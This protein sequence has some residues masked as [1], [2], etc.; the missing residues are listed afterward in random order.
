MIS[1]GDALNEH[2]HIQRNVATDIAVRKQVLPARIGY[3]FG[4]QTLPLLGQTTAAILAS[5]ENHRGF[6]RFDTAVG[7][8]FIGRSNDGKRRIGLGVMPGQ[9]A[10]ETH[11]FGASKGWVSG[12]SLTGTTAM[13]ASSKAWWVAPS[14]G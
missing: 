2:F 7:C 13:L 12:Y 11:P 1:S 4:N 14:K 9:Q 6:F 5:G 10:H 3:E 8:L